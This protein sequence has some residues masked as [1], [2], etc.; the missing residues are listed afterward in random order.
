[1]SRNQPGFGDWD[2]EQV[3]AEFFLKRLPAQG[4][5][6]WFPTSAMSAAEGT[7]ILFQYT[8]VVVASAELLEI[9]RYQRR[10]A[11]DGAAFHGAYLF[12]PL[13]IRTFKPVD[14]A[15]LRRFWPKFERFGHAKQV[16]S[17]PEAYLK[18]QR[19]LVDVR[20]VRSG[21]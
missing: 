8:G 11:I 16:L 19:S 20:S 9:E 12:D 3:Q 5:R 14:A 4:G 1:M 6:F 10:K 2:A 7:V 13:S 18:F 17:P 15:T 21:R